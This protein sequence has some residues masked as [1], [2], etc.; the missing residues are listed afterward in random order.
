MKSELYLNTE[1]HL[2][3]SLVANRR[4]FISP[5]GKP[6]NLGWN[7]QNPT[8]KQPI[9]YLPLNPENPEKNFGYGGDFSLSGD[10][11]ACASLP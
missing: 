4:K 2:D 3:I 9:M 6:A 8:G 1:T 5:E 7:G 11:N 10:G